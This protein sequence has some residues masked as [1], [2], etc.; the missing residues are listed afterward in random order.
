MK[1][2]LSSLKPSNCNRKRTLKRSIFLTRKRKTM[3]K[4]S[5]VVYTTLLKMINKK[6]SERF[7][8]SQP[9]MI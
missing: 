3:I 4:S 2:V 7:L 6:F 9:E 5:H 8:Q 1:N